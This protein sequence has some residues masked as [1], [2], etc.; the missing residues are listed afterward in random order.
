M[1]IDLDVNKSMSDMQL[2]YF[3][4]VILILSKKVYILL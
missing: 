3:L 1:T 4:V 2:F